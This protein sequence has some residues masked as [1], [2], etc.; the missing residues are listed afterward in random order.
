MIQMRVLIFF[1]A[2]LSVGMCINESAF[3]LLSNKYSMEVL[4]E[5]NYTTIYPVEGDKVTLHYE[6]MY[7]DLNVYD[8]SYRRGDKF[9]FNVGRGLVI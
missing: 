8:S 4:K 6:A 9:K 3:E 7:E 2:L 1:A 5:G